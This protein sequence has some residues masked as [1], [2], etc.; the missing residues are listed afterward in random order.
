MTGSVKDEVFEA[1]DRLGLSGR[2]LQDVKLGPGVVG[3]NST[4]AWV[5]GIVMLA[6][7]VGGT[8]LHS[9]ILVGASIV[10]AV[11]V[12]LG[13]ACL[14]VH[15]ARTNPAAA[16]LEGAQFVEY[17][18]LQLTAARG[19]EPTPGGQPVPPPAQI[20]GAEKGA[21]SERSESES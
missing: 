14:N 11:V 17:H 13:V 1:M 3:R 8:W 18:H 20:A 15:F 16:L 4:V 9:T 5:V 19:M 7:V 21:L 6:G 12:G 2:Q 10:G